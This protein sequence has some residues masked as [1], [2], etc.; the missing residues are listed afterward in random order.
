MK[1][2]NLPVAAFL[3]GVGHTKVYVVKI[4]ETLQLTHTFQAS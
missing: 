3:E 4:L 2:N 1:S